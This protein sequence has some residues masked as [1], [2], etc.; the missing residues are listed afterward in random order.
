VITLTQRQADAI[1]RAKC[2]AAVREILQELPANTDQE[3]LDVVRLAA[4]AGFA[5]GW[6]ASASAVKDMFA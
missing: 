4:E 6:T 1:Y 3:I 2:D 5:Q